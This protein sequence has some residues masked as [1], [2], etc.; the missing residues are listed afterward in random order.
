[1]PA[2]QTLFRLPLRTPEQATLSEMT[3]TR[4][5]IN[6]LIKDIFS[7]RAEECLLFTPLIS[8]SCH[9]RDHRGVTAHLWSSSAVRQDVT[10]TPSF[11]QRV[12]S[13][14]R[15]AAQQD[16]ALTSSYRQQRI[17]VTVKTASSVL[18]GTHTLSKR[19]TVV[20]TQIARPKELD[21]SVAEKHRLPMQMHLGVATPDIPQSSSTSSTM[22]AAMPLPINAHLPICI[23][24]S[25]ILADD[26]RSIRFDEASIVNPESE[27]NRWL[28]KEAI[29][30]VYYNLLSC[31]PAK[32]FD[33]WPR[34]S[35]KRDPYA[36]LV[37]D[38]FYEG[39]AQCSDK[40]CVDV[41]NERVSPNVAVFMGLAH[42]SIRRVFSSF[43]QPK[44]LVDLPLG[45]QARALK[46]GLVGL[47]PDRAQSYL[48]S[49]ADA[50]IDRFVSKSITVLD[51]QHVI[52]YLGSSRLM[53][54]PLLPLADNTLAT[55]TVNRKLIFIPKE[56]G[57]RPWPFLPASR[58]THPDIRL[59]PYLKAPASFLNIALLSGAALSQL[60]RDRIP[61]GPARN[62]SIED[63]HWARQVWS[64]IERLSEPTGDHVDIE[65]LPLVPTTDRS[66]HISLRSC[67][68]GSSNILVSP[69]TSQ[70]WLRPFMEDLG[71]TFIE[72]EGMP[73]ELQN[74]LGQHAQF[75]MFAVSNFLCS[76]GAMLV[77]AAVGRLSPTQQSRLAEWIVLQ[78]NQRTQPASQKRNLNIDALKTLPIWACFN[79]LTG[80]AMK[81][82]TVIEMLPEGMP[83]QVARQFL[84]VMDIIAYSVTIQGL[85]KRPMTY[86]QLRN[87]LIVPRTLEH[88]LVTSYKTLLRDLIAHRTLD[89]RPPLVPNRQGVM[90]LPSDLYDS[91]V[92]VFVAA[93]VNEPHRF[94]HN[95]FLEFETSLKHYNFHHVVNFDNFQT[96]AQAIDQD[97]AAD[98]LTRAQVLYDWY[99]TRLPTEMAGDIDNRWRLLDHLRFIPVH[100]QRRRGASWGETYTDGFRRDT[101]CSPAQILRPECE[102]IAWT[103][104]ALFATAPSQS[105]LVTDLDLGVP[106]PQQ[107]VSHEPI[108]LL[109]V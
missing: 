16:V 9:V 59:R 93:F 54:L 98:V 80:H 88:T 75:D 19:W 50:F 41:T 83:V 96:A 61:D 65:T 37:I 74:H 104:R 85:G 78:L 79:S 40:I 29:P 102:S 43:L 107:V 71:A 3:N 25:F 58:F 87:K 64:A 11:P 26:R 36:E 6:D 17:H 12:S 72:P 109:Y 94:V 84:P 70:P 48:L 49:T 99:N 60:I 14:W 92:P 52:D 32:V 31:M 13:I 2:T 106:S 45:I 15:P 68:S 38:G 42:T 86:S 18:I 57:D 35:S 33:W 100:S 47:D 27:F 30:P 39:L 62:L 90:C 76:K 82:L 89:P 95:Q 66:R 63:A 46:S 24:A 105:L 5:N 69:T 67:T 28:L 20:T 81:T 51:V 4:S 1:M 10:M 101:L 53:D 73:L 56:S 108:I 34:A 91:R 21:D 77:G 55:F 8:L 103:Q 97:T 22:F 23:N 44:G 7:R